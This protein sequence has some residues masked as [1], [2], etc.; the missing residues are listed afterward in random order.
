MSES[1]SRNL[2][3]ATA[4]ASGA[5]LVAGCGRAEKVS[6]KPDCEPF[7]VYAQNRFPAPSGGFGAAVRSGP[8]I[9]APLIGSYAGNA[10]IKAI[11]YVITN[12]QAY[13]TNPEPID[14]DHWIVVETDDDTGFISDAGVRAGK[15]HRDKSGLSQKLGSTVDFD[16]LPEAC[17]ITNDIR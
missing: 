11:G 12:K 8:D 15:T 9:G 4:I 5:L 16:A 1:L 6:D 7:I 2:K 14:G 13:P 10:Q 3:C 17:N